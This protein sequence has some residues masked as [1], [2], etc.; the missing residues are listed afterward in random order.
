MFEVEIIWP[1]NNYSE[2]DKFNVKA[3]DIPQYDINAV[4]THWFGREY[5]MVGTKKFEDVTMSIYAGENAHILNKLYTW[6]FRCYNTLTNGYKIP[7]EYMSK[8]IITLINIENGE[9]LFKYILHD[10][11]PKVIDNKD[12][13]EYNADSDYLN[14]D[15]LFAVA[16]VRDELLFNGESRRR[17]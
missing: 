7:S 12:R 9:G 8:I 15:V 17:V 6:H 14:Y 2:S 11:W 13:L 3:I 10:A 4:S 5:Q 16:E 1:F